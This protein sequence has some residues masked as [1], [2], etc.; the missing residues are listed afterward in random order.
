M[1]TDD[2]N[3]ARCEKLQF[4]WY[5]KY[6]PSML[7][8]C[9]DM[10]INGVESPS[11]AVF[12]FVIMAVDDMNGADLWRTNAGDEKEINNCVDITNSSWACLLFVLT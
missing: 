1:A 5:H 7:T 3:G 6:L 8:V 4:R 11:M 12:V 9:A 10:S 2:M